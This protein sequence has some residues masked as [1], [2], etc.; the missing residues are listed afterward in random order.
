MEY[1]TFSGH[2]YPQNSIDLVP[3]TKLTPQKKTTRETT[4]EGYYVLVSNRKD[5]AVPY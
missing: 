1:L 3:F 5:V 4:I 2:V